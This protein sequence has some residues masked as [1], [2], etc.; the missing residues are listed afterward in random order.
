LAQLLAEGQ[1]T[2]VW[3]HQ[4]QNDRIRRG[5]MEQFQSGLAVAH[6]DYAPSIHWQIEFND[7]KNEEVIL[8]HQNHRFYLFK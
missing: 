7:F 8:H 5:I 2:F 3:Q 4:V 1:A 6:G